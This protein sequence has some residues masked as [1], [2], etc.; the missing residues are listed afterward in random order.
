MLYMRSASE[1][2][3]A[4][5]RIRDTAIDAFA[6]EGFDRVSLRQVAREAGVSPA[7]VVHHFGDKDGLRAACD[8][9][10]LN[11]VLSEKRELGTSAKPDLLRAALD[12]FGGNSVHVDYLGRMLVEDSASA[13]ALF[14]T[15]LQATRETLQEQADAGMLRAGEDLEAM[16][17][18]LTVYGLGPVILRH[19][20]ARAFGADRLTVAVLE[21]VSLPALEIFTHGIYTDD[22]LLS[23][24]R[25]ALARGQHPHSRDR[26]EHPPHETPAEPP[27][28]EE[29]AP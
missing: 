19:H 18:L 27:T 12:D 14:D 28:G 21:R 15:L 16:A 7:L 22:R 23:A 2:L 4:R 8:E 13:A 6:R 3:T 1:D 10:V 25:E 5:A 29:K 17:V 9:H 11:H 26:P 20:F 24:T